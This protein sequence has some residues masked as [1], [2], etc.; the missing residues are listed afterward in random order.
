MARS[1]ARWAALQAKH[2]TQALV[3][4]LGMTMEHALAA[5]IDP[6]QL[7]HLP[8]DV[9]VHWGADGPALVAAGVKL[10]HL[11]SLRCTPMQLRDALHLDMDGLR[12]LGLERPEHMIRLCP[13]ATLRDWVEAMGDTVADVVQTQHD[14]ETAGYER[15]DFDAAQ[16]LLAAL[17][18]P[19]APDVRPVGARVANAGTRVGEL[20]F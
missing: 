9:L 10:A 14:A 3:H 18:A 11:A 7:C 12:H 15:A 17:N 19:P 16:T 5:K 1:G 6:A 4:E 20:V 8:V 2:G 13:A